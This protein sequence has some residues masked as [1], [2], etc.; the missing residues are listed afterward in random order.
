[1]DFGKTAYYDPS[2]MEI[3]VYVDGRHPK[4]MLRS[5]SHELVHHTQNCRGD[6]DFQFET[7]PGYAQNNQKLRELEAEAYLLGNGFLVRDFED[8]IKLG[9]K[10]LMEWKNKEKKKLLKEEEL[11]KLSQKNLETFASKKQQDKLTSVKSLLNQ[12]F[13]KGEDQL[14]QKIVD[15]NLPLASKHQLFEKLVDMFG[16][17]KAGFSR[18]RW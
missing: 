18:R 13:D 1:M 11:A 17:R 6:F 10:V 4:D 12:I 7:E 14:A 8:S 5:I 9:D 3:V 2:N 15:M 16:L